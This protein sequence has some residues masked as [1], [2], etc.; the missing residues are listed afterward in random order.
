[1]E[2]SASDGA[3]GVGPSKSHLVRRHV[4]LQEVLEHF[5]STTQV[6]SILGVDLDRAREGR[7]DA[8]DYVRRQERV[9]AALL[10]D[11]AV[12]RCVDGLAAAPN[13]F[14]LGPTDKLRRFAQRVKMG[15]GA[16]AVAVLRVYQPW[17]TQWPEQGLAHVYGWMRDRCPSLERPELGKEASLAQAFR[18]GKAK[19]ARD[20][21]A[22]LVA[23]AE[24]A[25]SEWV[26]R[27]NDPEGKRGRR[28][29]AA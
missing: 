27:W 13:L 9:E 24:I 23:D 4:S 7:S 2:R 16:A 3:A 5:A 8:S 22:V 11:A 17:A 20:A 12:L 10:A 1:M 15:E 28:A 29:A 21:A 6:R 25:I 14:R 26:A 18:V 19:R